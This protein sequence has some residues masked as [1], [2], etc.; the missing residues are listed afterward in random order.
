[1]ANKQAFESEVKTI[2]G[3]VAGEALTSDQYKAVVLSSGAVIKCTSLGQSPL[4]ILQNAPA[5]GEAASVAYA[6]IGHAKI[7]GNVSQQ[8]RLV[9]DTDAMR[10]VQADPD[11]A[12][13]AIALSDGVDG[14]V[15]P[16]V[17]VMGTAL[18][19]AVA[20][21]ALANTKIWIGDSAGEAQAFAMSGDAT[22]T[23]GGVITVTDVTVGSDATGDIL[24]KSSATA[25]ARLGIGTATQLLAVNGGATA[26]EWISQSAISVSDI[27]TTAAGDAIG[28]LIYR[29]AADTFERLAIGTAS[30]ILQTNAGATA[31]E[32]NS[33]SG[34]ATMAAG[35]ITVTDVTVGSDA[36]GDIL[37]KSS[38]TAL[39][40]LGIGTAS[41][42][43]QTNAGATAPEWNS[44]SGHATMAAGVITVTDLDTTAA[45]DAIGDLIYRDA[46]NTFE[47]LAKGTAGD[48]LQQNAGATA[49]QWATVSGDATIADGGA[50]TV[51]DVTVGSDAQGDILYKD[52]TPAC[53]RLAAGTAGD[54][55]QQDS[56]ATAPQWATMSGDATIADGGAIR[57]AKGFMR[58]AT[59]TWTAAQVKAGNVTPLVLVDFAVE[60]AAGRIAA[61]DA[62]IFHDLVAN[63]YGGAA[64]YDQNEN[65]IIKYQTAGGGATVSTTLANWFNGAGAGTITTI[66]QLVTDVVPDADEDLVWTM[67]ASPYAAAGDRTLSVTVYYSVFTPAS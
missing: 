51:A 40:R 24:Y 14:N 50:V 3:F 54:I 44:M 23:A 8:N 29:D 35:V 26:P 9:T 55:L 19:S 48:I 6:G 63:I 38:A 62:L 37:Y 41:Q 12:V 58:Q 59:T 36:T 64:N 46:A 60:Q 25:L 65:S 31:P 2:P 10:I 61:G 11:E 16:V 32:W 49:P 33:M 13:I 56:G 52:A 66:K 17:Y 53:A 4:G 7:G 34:D 15:I 57:I 18:N 27:A 42:I 39:A 5:S 1:M 45:G 30:Q 67:S 21:R 20:E 22:M 47:R 28:D 43:L